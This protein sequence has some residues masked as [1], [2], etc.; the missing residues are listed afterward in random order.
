MIKNVNSPTQ[1]LLWYFA[2][3]VLANGQATRTPVAV[4]RGGYAAE[5][6]EIVSA[7]GQLFTLSLYGLDYF[8]GATEGLKGLPLPKSLNGLS[9]TIQQGNESFVAPLLGI[10]QRRCPP[11]PQPCATLTQLSVQIPYELRV[12]DGSAEAAE[13]LSYIIVQENGVN[14]G[15]T[16]LRLVKDSVHLAN[17]CDSV[18]A[19]ETGTIGNCRTVVV[20]GDGSYVT[21]QAPAK[22][23]EY[24]TMYAFGLGK[25]FGE[26]R[27]GDGTPSTALYAPVGKFVVTARVGSNLAPQR[28]SPDDESIASYVGLAPGFVGL[29]QV[30][31]RVPVLPAGT[32]SCRPG[33]PLESNLTVTLSGEFSF[34]G[35][36]ICVLAG[37][38]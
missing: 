19:V 1:L 2:F 3:S 15:S 25:V 5:A 24:L 11:S 6:P 13:L 35:T 10:S 14:R 17:T 9:V 30:N 12:N 27:S 21:L 29:Y 8:N 36:G 34:A 33:G 22:G 20:H 26:I 28:G 23:G 7:P 18:F 31:F 4:A 32:Q 16:S 37:G 38:A